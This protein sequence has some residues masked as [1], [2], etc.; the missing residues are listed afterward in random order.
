MK[1]TVSK[2]KGTA[3]QTVICEPKSIKSLQEPQPNVMNYIIQQQHG[4]EIDELTK[5]EHYA[6]NTTKVASSSSISIF[7]HLEN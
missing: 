3:D 6:K 5:S 1:P 4:S 7:K 2:A